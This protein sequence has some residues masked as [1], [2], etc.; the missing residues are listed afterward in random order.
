LGTRHSPR[1]LVFEGRFS[2]TARAVHAARS[3]IRVSAL[4]ATHPSRRRATARL[5]G[6]RS[7]HVMTQSQTLMV[8]RRIG[9]SRTMRPPV[10][11]VGSLT[12]EQLRRVAQRR[13]CA[14]PTICV[15][16]GQNGGHASTFALRA[17]ADTSLLPTLRFLKK[18]PP[19]DRNGGLAGELGFEPRQTESESVVLP[20][21][22]S[23]PKPLILQHFFGSFAIRA[24]SFAN[25]AICSADIAGLTFAV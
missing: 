22:H 23:P 12:I 10:G 16:P 8:R 15:V 11:N 17:T 7:L 1:P 6:T 9:P 13:A 19:G 21:H 5:L 3:R 18:E 20:L 14:V 25:P 24:R 4:V 2:G